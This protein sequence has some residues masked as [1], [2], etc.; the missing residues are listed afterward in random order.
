MEQ[1]SFME[2]E[3]EES[4]T[5]I[6]KQQK[7]GFH[8]LDE[9]KNRLLKYPPYFVGTIARGSS[10]HA[11][12]FA[13]Y[14]IETQMGIITTSIS[15]SVHTVY[16][17]KLSYKN[18]FVIGISQSGKSDDLLECMAVARKNGAITLAFVN[19]NNSPLEKE[20]EYCIPL[21]AGKENS[22]AATKSF[23]ASLSRIIQFV[24]H[25]SGNI[26]LKNHLT[27]LP[28]LITNNSFSHFNLALNELKNEKSILV[29]GRGFAFPIALESALKFKET[30]GLHAEAFSGAEI[31]HGPFELVHKNFPV[32]VY[33]Q[34][35]KTM[36]GMLKFIE[37]LQQKE[38]KVI[39]F[40]AQNILNSIHSTILNKI[41]TI[42]TNESLDPLCDVISLIHRF[43]SFAAS[44][45]I[46]TGRNPDHPL[47]LNKVTRTV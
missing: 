6:A 23:I 20:S 24:A 17:S 16:K 30:C 15:P 34:N 21:L 14:A 35:D 1:K 38:A 28:S 13:K 32:L 47:N 18:S 44:L 45:S 31:L 12:Y 37:N 39:V 22:V 8:I 9:L 41:L 27:N 3:S 46:A 4:P 29:I 5:I 25:W 19:E 42:S 10:D 43:Y 11:A 33:L 36:P 2:S 26:D 40:A 7:N